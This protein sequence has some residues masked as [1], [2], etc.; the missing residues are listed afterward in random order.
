MGYVWDAVLSREKQE[1]LQIKQASGIVLVTRFA[2]CRTRAGEGSTER[3][4]KGD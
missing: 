3:R 4:N 1:V 2:G